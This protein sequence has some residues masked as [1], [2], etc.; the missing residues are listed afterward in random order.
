MKKK[1]CL[2][3]L[4]I[5]LCG[6][7][8]AQ[9]LEK[10]LPG[11]KTTF[12]ANPFWHNWFVSFNAGVN[13]LRAEH[14]G[15]ADFMNTLTFM[16]VL[17][18]GKWF[19]PWWGVRAQGGGG[20]YHGFG[21]NADVMLHYHYM[22]VHADAMVGLINF[23]APYKENRKFDIVPF[24]GIGGMTNSKDQSFTI[25]AGI[26]FR[27]AL[28]SR[29]D[30]NIEASGMLLDDDLV[31]RSG[32]PNDG[33]IG[34]TGGITYRFKNREFK[35]APSSDELAALL[36]ANLLLAQEVAALKNRIPEEV[37]VVE[38][39]DEIPANKEAT[40]SSSTPYRSVSTTIPFKF[41]SSVLENTYDPIIYNIATFMKDNPDAKVRIV[42]YADK[43]GP[44]NVNMK[45]S[46]QR[47]NVVAKALASD[48]GI[49]SDRIQVEY[50]GKE[51]PFY[52]ENNKWNRCAIVDVIP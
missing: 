8:G 47:A 13:S 30:I 36:A 43:F 20:A 24:V 9:I 5:G 49:S 21:P 35:K 39:V 11:Y 4:A 51:K 48:Y 29:F 38:E 19:N 18:V 45:I 31:Q 6:T 34:L 14:S 7:A 1:L 2:I 32:F 42:G 33:I 3:V 26:Q 46:E 23:F 27:Y 17:S 44:I 37:I 28:S 41:N 25:N 40:P 50:V 10:P 16:P 15:D 52:K 12:Q 22:Y